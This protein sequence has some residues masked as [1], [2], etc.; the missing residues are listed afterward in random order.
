MRPVENV[1]NR[2]SLE[3]RLYSEKHNLAPITRAASH[4]TNGK[5][6]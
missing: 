2:F 6:S 5:D 1:L 4:Q 3:G